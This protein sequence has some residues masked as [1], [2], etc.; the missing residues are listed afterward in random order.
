[1][2]D[3][4][5]AATQVQHLRQQASCLLEE[6]AQQHDPGQRDRLLREALALLDHARV[7]REWGDDQ[8][9]MAAQPGDGADP[10]HARRN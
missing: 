9:R 4:E 5:A 2:S 6:A 1:M 8:A 3:P 7:L 10:C